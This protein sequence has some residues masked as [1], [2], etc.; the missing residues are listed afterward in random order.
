VSDVLDSNRELAVPESVVDLMAGRLGQP[1]GG[2][3]RAVQR[4]VLKGAKPLRGRPGASL[5]PA[6]FEAAAATL[7]KLI[8][9]PPELREII[10]HLLY[11]RVFQ[12]F[13]AHRQAYSD[14]SVLPTPVF[15]YGIEK[16]EEVAVEIERGKTLI[17]KFLNVGDP[18]PDGRR[19]VFF[20]LNGQPRE[21]TVQDHS[22]EVE[23]SRRPK[24]DTS[25]PRQ[26]AAPM[27]GL[28]VTVAVRAGDA[29]TQGQKLAVL[30][31]MKMETVLTAPYAGRVSEVL[32]TAGTQV[33]AGD[34]LVTLKSHAHREYDHTPTDSL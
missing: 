10:S 12:E 29:V 20:E 14:T 6:D 25:D 30:E 8:G 26:I 21:T 4:R 2:F 24:A 18:H 31:A 17:I 34:L 15:F 13:A 5:P 7:Q 3:P 11:P 19:T 16:G 22:L 27:P 28:V 23:V 9:R 32:V 1:P 33:D